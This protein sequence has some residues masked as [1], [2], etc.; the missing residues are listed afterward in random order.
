MTT[1]YIKI[2]YGSY[3]ALINKSIDISEYK[4]MYLNLFNIFKKQNPDDYVYYI[5]HDNTDSMNIYAEI[6]CLETGWIYNTI[7]VNTVELCRISLIK[8]DNTIDINLL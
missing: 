2:S 5:Y 1:H 7:S 4:K 3:E 8:I 6:E